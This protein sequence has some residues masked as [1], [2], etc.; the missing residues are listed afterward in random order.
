MA[1]ISSRKP[2]DLEA[3]NLLDG[4]PS[5]LTRGVPDDRSFSNLSWKSGGILMDKA[6]IGP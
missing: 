1:P 2:K 3:P 6:D 5:R 4:E